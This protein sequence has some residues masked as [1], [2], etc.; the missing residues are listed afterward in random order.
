MDIGNGKQMTNKLSYAT[1]AN[2]CPFDKALV[3]RSVISIVDQLKTR[4][5]Q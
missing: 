1:S 3:K 2:I 5:A 4:I